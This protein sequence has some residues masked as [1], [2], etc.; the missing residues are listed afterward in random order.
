M[1][2]EKLEEVE[3][4]GKPYAKMSE[5]ELF[6]ECIKGFKVYKGIHPEI[7]CTREYPTRKEL[8]GYNIGLYL[9]MFSNS[10]LDKLDVLSKE[11]SELEHKL[12]AQ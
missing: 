1:K 9:I 11:K 4:R 8:F 3:E 7:D 6:E 10:L 2:V 5:C 12:K